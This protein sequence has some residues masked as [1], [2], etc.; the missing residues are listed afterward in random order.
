[1]GT[2]LFDGGAPK[3][4]TFLKKHGGGQ[5]KVVRGIPEWLA[6]KLQSWKLKRNEVEIITE[7]SKIR[8]RRIYTEEEYD[9]KCGIQPPKVAKVILDKSAALDDI[10]AQLALL[11]SA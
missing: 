2:N 4:A 1:M 8:K 10:E 9:L 7:P 11:D 3:L 6:K 5:P